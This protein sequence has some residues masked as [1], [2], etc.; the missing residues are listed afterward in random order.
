MLASGEKALNS[1]ILNED[2]KDES[3]ANRIYFVHLDKDLLNSPELIGKPI[4]SSADFDNSFRNFLINGKI[5]KSIRYADFISKKDS[6]NVW[7]CK[8][9]VCLL[10][11]DPYFLIKKG[12]NKARY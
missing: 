6:L 1:H 11:D 7:E 4:I 3:I 12:G 8:G 2:I 9:A 10:I 5:K